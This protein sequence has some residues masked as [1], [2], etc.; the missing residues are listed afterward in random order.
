[1]T[2]CMQH[3]RYTHKSLFTIHKF[4]ESFLKKEEKNVF[5]LF[6]FIDVKV[7][8]NCYIRVICVYT[9]EKPHFI[10]TLIQKPKVCKHS[11][12]AI[13]IQMCDLKPK[14]SLRFTKNLFFRNMQTQRGIRTQRK[15]YIKQISQLSFFPSLAA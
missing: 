13:N 5:Y 9:K 3:I 15:W 6:Q 7:C 10:C 14:N 1:M 2:L 4:G 8:I 11:L 12:D